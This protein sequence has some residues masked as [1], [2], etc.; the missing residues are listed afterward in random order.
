MT[1]RGRTT[2]LLA[3]GVLAVAATLLICPLFGSRAIDLG[4][5]LSE[6]GD[7]RSPDA[8]VFFQL[9]LPRVL[10]AM[11]VGASLS[12]AGM[13]LQGLTRNGLA[14][15]YT[16][17]VASGGAFGAVLALRLGLAGTILGLPLSAAAALLGAVLVAVLVLGWASR[18][19]FDSSSLL[20]SGVTIGMI[21]SA[22]ILLV[23]YLSDATQSH[24]MV[25]WLMGGMDVVG[26][27]S[28]LGILPLVATGALLVLLHAGELNQL[29]QGDDLA[30]ARGVAVR[31]VRGA[32]LAGVALLTG[33]AVSVAGPIGFVGLI[34]PHTLRLLGGL[35]H[36]RLAPLA[37]LWGAVFL[38]V[39]DTIARTVLA[40]AEIPVG[41][42]TALLGGPFFLWV[43]GSRR[44]HVTPL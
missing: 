19:G 4:K 21:A 28:L 10:C 34:V 23:Q 16:L 1:E 2:V 18:G 20:L 7:P 26:Y 36:R 24:L 14:S 43:L 6:I 12:L 41:V 15:E 40:P 5:A 17:G 27:G 37:A 30:A 44:R 11:L 25:R 9:R 39:C 29:L 33:A 32:V 38:A 22:G 35:D 8:L 3:A 31:R 42:L 13:A